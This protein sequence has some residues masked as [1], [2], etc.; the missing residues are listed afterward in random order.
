MVIVEGTDPLTGKKAMG[1]VVLRKR[2]E[3][4]V[5][6]YLAKWMSMEYAFDESEIY[7]FDRFI[8]AFKFI[9]KRSLFRQL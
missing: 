1:K 6:F 5:S 8:Q 2:G 4:E 7:G 3:M 9:K